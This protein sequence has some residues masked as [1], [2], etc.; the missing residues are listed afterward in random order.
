MEASVK[1]IEIILRVIELALDA[2]SVA[3]RG[4][5]DTQNIVRIFRSTHKGL[6]D[7]LSGTESVEDIFKKPLSEIWGGDRNAPTIYEVRKAVVKA[8]AS[9]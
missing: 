1:I 5:D 3:T 2:I 9:E 6:A 4:D 8:R 7:A